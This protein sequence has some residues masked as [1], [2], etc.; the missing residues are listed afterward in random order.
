MSFAGGVMNGEELMSSAGAMIAGFFL[1]DLMW[2][3]GRMYVYRT[4]P[5][6]VVRISV[7]YS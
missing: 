7:L 5:Y 6:F 2:L 4:L 1:D 3:A